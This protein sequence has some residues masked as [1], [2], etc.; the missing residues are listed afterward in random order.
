MNDG[1]SA[2]AV[3]GSDLYA[4]GG[5]KTAGGVVAN[6]IAKWKGS[7]WSAFGTGMNDGVSALAVSGSDVYAGGVFTTAG[8]TPANCIAKWNGSEWSA[9]GT[10]L[11]GRVYALAAS[12]SDV[13]AGGV[14]TTAGGTPANCIAKWNGSEWSPLGTGMNNYVNALV[15]IGNDLY[16]GGAFTTAGGVVNT[17]YIAKWNGSAWSALGNGMNDPV[18]ALAVSGS[19]LYAGGYFSR[20]GGSPANRIAKWNGSMWSALG[21]GFDG[22]VY[23]LAVSGSDIYAGGDFSVASGTSVNYI[24]KWNGSDWSAFGTGMNDNVN[25]LTIDRTGHLYLGGIFTVVGTIVSPF[26]AQANITFPTVTAISPTSGTTLGGTSVTI[27]GTNLSGA[28]AVTIGGV[29]ATNVV[30]VDSTRIT[31]TSPANAQGTASVLATTPDGTS[32][33]NMLYTYV[34]PDIAVTHASPLIDGA[35]SVQFGAT[36]G[37]KNEPL[38]FAITNTGSADLTSLEVTKDGPDAAL[39]SVSSISATSIPV[40]SGTAIFTV[41]F[42]PK[43]GGVKTAALHIASNVNGAKNPFD[44]AITGTGRNASQAAQTLFF[45]P[46]SKLY[47]AESSFTLNA[48]ASSGLPVVY[49]VISG[50][51]SVSGNVLNFTGAGTVKV[52][53]SQP[54]NADFMAATPVERTITVATNPAALTLT[55][56]SQTYTGTPLP[57]TVLGASGAVDVTYKVGLVYVPTAPINPGSYLVKAVAGSITKTG[58]L[59]I[60]KAPLFVTPD[61]QRKFAGQANPVLGFGYSGFLGSDDAANSVSKAPVIA[62]TATA[63][64]A[65]GLYPI[66]A[67]GG[68]STNYLFVYLKG[69]MKVETFA[70]S[71]EALLVDDGP[72][73][74]GKLSITVTAT[75][76]TFTAKLGTATETSAVSFTGPLLTVGEEATGNATTLVGTG[77]IP[78][79]ID[80]TLPIAGSVI[81]SATRNSLPLG[82]ANDGQKLSSKIVAYAGVHTAVLE[83]ATPAGSNVPGGAGWATASINTA[84]VITLTGKLGDGTAF[85]SA[86][87]PDDSI[88]PGYRLFVQPYLTAR[89]QS[90]LAG[91]FSLVKH[92]TLTG[93]RYLAQSSLTW[94]KTSL[95][96]DVSYRTSFGPVKTVMMIDP[97]LA[98]KTTAPTI[99]LAQRLGLTGSSF[100]V[101]HSDTGSASQADLPTRLSLSTANTVSVLTPLANLTK[102]KTLT[103]MPTT[104]T[105]TG[106]F[107]LTDAIKRPVTLSGILRQPATSPDTLIGEGH[108][109]LPPLTGTERTTGEVMFTRP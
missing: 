74:V 88:N 78:C 7:A 38:T 19:D 63:A 90:F 97:W 60:T 102:W 80:F 70:G 27:T 91:S 50:P 103:F 15:V 59:L 37:V 98:P 61:D 62:T 35:D 79:R 29:A 54:G 94:K 58:T 3:G 11:D 22:T 33:A 75:S 30:V 49:T 44:I 93:R 28:S 45:T 26:I 81:A 46:P 95:S 76:K 1:V 82:G 104:G 101:I 96:A 25:A 69:T 99:A 13:Y 55:N 43:S 34:M 24:A 71:Y 31:A 107:D 16:A 10:G 100:G 41:T 5:F 85:T 64:S 73:P 42:S 48:S 4:G 68:T 86:L 109:L 84:G 20:A 92:P 32:V 36:L 66:T 67:S 9:L 8:G 52:R 23:A 39:F 40:G 87:S 108:Y 2:L 57:I 18:N 56:L 77:K 83:P 14:F 51:A 12:G 105:F 6:G 17:L 89:A 106:S 53:A 72:K 65:G 47:L 21:L